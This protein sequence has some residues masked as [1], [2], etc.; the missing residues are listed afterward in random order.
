MTL[1]RAGPGL[2]R[3]ELSPLE[4]SPLAAEHPDALLRRLG[5]FRPP[6][7]VQTVEYEAARRR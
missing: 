2:D 1:A 6:R 5:P 7:T 4:L 3:L